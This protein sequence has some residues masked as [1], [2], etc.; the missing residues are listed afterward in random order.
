MI[1][2][3]QCIVL[4]DA[5]KRLLLPV[6]VALA[7]TPLFAVENNTLTAAEEAAGWKLLFDGK[8]ASKWW[9]GY[10]Q[11]RFPDKWAAR[12][13]VLVCEGGGDIITKDQFESFEL[14]L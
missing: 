4:N 12:D 2:R 6:L 3:G 5:M 13:G 14:S 9:R 8:D 7:A 10:K 11:E 1:A